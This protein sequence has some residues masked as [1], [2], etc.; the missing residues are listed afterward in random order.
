VVSQLF[1]KIRSIEGGEESVTN[2]VPRR[3]E[4][5]QFGCKQQ[6]GK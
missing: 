4:R 6:F 5:Q 1:E 2:G 3:K